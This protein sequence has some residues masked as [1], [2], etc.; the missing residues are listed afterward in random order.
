MVRNST[1][2]SQKEP[3]VRETKVQLHLLLQAEQRA[4][5]VGAVTQ[6]H[7][8]SHRDAAPSAASFFSREFLTQS[9]PLAFPIP[10]GARSLFFSLPLLHIC[11]SF[12]LVALWWL[13]LP[14]P[15]SCLQFW[16]VPV[17]AAPGCL[18]CSSWALPSPAGVFAVAGGNQATAA[19]LV[20][21]MQ[22]K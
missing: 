21:M 4:G 2:R 6:H 12:C 19:V 13:W 11:P 1:G 5:L 16:V 9:C 20:R 7:E 18:S 22:G 17:P 10:E 14:P 8:T 15:G 3:Q